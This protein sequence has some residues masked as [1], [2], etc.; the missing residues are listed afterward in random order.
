[1]HLESNCS[2]VN[3]NDINKNDNS[4]NT[5]RKL[6]VNNPLRTIVGQLNISS[7]RNTF[8]ALCN[9]SKQKIE[10]LLISETKV[11]DIFPLAQLC[12]E[13]YSTP[14]K[15]VRTCKGGVF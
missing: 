5:V 7:I 4:C 11:D 6:R 2:G 1:M 3:K 13:G 10:V 15:L 9:I 8:D 14:Y 12:V